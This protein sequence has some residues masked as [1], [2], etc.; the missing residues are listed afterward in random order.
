MQRLFVAVPVP[1]ELSGGLV[2]VMEGFAGADWVPEESLHLTLRFIGEVDGSL[3]RDCL[4]AL[5]QVRAAAFSIAITGVD[6][7]ET[8]GMVRTLWAGI[9]RS[10]D[11]AL[12]HDRI[13]HALVRAGCPPDRRRFTPHV[14][15]ARVAEAAPVRVI[16]WLSRHAGLSL[17]PWS[18]ST[19]SVYSSWRSG[20]GPIY[21]EEARFAL[22]GAPPADW[23]DEPSWDEV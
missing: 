17:G 23:E 10:P 4:D 8:K 3:A 12:L 14:T 15:L 22:D 6:R 21:R 16:D 1:E 11:L 5:D 20:S 7:F 9:T 13:D 2:D 18:I 19:F